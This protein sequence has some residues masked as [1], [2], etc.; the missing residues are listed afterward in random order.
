MASFRIPLETRLFPN[1]APVKGQ[2]LVDDPRGALWLAEEM[3][4]QENLP[5]ETQQKRAAKVRRHRQIAIEEDRPRVSA[6]RPSSIWPR[7]GI[8]AS[9]LSMSNRALSP[10]SIR[11]TNTSTTNQSCGSVSLLESIGTLE[12][13]VEMKFNIRAL[14]LMC[15]I[16]LPYC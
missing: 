7:E 10:T 2:L 6:S 14:T 11:T 8:M 4:E 9:A 13:N 12:P 3:E 15:Q 16:Y 5:V 1:A